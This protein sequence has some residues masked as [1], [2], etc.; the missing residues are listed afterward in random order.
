MELDGGGKERRW[1]E[2][3]RVHPVSYFTSSVLIHSYCA[4]GAIPDAGHGCEYY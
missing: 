3:G 2:E 4:P 1:D